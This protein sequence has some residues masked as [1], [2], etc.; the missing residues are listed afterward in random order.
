MCCVVIHTSLLCVF[1]PSFL[2]ALIFLSIGMHSSHV[3]P[4][5]VFAPHVS[6]LIAACVPHVF[7]VSCSWILAFS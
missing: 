6:H 1:F 7:L 3:F 5:H 4:S 2:F